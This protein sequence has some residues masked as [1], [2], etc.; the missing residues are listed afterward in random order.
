MDVRGIRASAIERLERLNLV[1]EGSAEAARTASW[2][3]IAMGTEVPAVDGTEYAA[4]DDALHGAEA[5]M[6][7]PP[8]YR[9]ELHSSVANNPV[10]NGALFQSIAQ[11]QGW[12]VPVPVDDMHARLDAVEAELDPALVADEL[13]DAAIIVDDVVPPDVAPGGTPVVDAPTAWAT[14]DP[15]APVD[16]PVVD[17]ITEPVV[18]VI[19][20]PVDDNV[21]ISPPRAVRRNPLWREGLQTP[22]TAIREAIEYAIRI[23]IRVR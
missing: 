5:A 8:A 11:E 13:G 10:R 4:V 7:E 22:E 21:G 3:D 18:D 12:Y 20:E 1:E 23:G 14:A 16:V 17:V 9:W 6:T 19:T 15:V 2:R